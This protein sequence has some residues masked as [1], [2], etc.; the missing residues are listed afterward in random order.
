MTTDARDGT[1]RVHPDLDLWYGPRGATQPCDRT[2]AT[3]TRNP[4]LGPRAHDPYP[5]LGPGPRTRTQGRDSDPRA[6]VQPGEP[7][8]EAH[9][10]ARDLDP[11]P[12]ARP[13][14]CEP[15]PGARARARDLDPRPGP[16]GNATRTSGRRKLT[17]A[18]PGWRG[19][20]WQVPPHHSADGPVG[21]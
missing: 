18:P 12:D 1:P 16:R 21:E 6:G 14:P 9:A 20:T 2:P 4:G 15:D 7:D 8:P 19:L 17:G 5:D 3:E 13:A 11:D 10:W